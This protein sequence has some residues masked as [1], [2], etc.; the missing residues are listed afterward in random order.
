[1]RHGR[2]RHETAH[3]TLRVRPAAPEDAAAVDALVA[4]V[5]AEDRWFITGAGEYAGDAAWHRADL[6]RLSGA[7]NSLA[8]VGELDGR[9]VALATARGGALHR[10]RHVARVEF[11]VAA[12]VRDGGIGSVLVGEV[13]RRAQERPLIQKLSLAVFADN[14]RAIALYRR[15]GFVE[16]GRRIGEYRERDGRLR[17]DVLMAHRVDATPAPGG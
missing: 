6:R 15:H 12:D 11:Y 5:Y 14:A 2:T 10:T 4:A 8:L 16:E 13:V 9:L 1:M 3:G 7:A 17:D